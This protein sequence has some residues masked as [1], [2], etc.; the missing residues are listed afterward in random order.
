MKDN[1]RYE[2]VAKMLENLA[3]KGYTTQDVAQ[4]VR[5]M[6]EVLP[7]A[8]EQQD[9]A[10]Q[11]SLKMT[12]I[13]LMHEVGVP[14]HIKGYRYLC[15]AIIMAVENPQVLEGMT[16]VLYPEVAKTFGT[17]PSRTERAIRHAIEATWDRADMDV[18]KK[19]FGNTIS[20]MRGKATNSEFIATMAEYIRNYKM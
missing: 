5:T 17:T 10:V 4:L 12:V 1:E 13:G 16:K 18:L 8:P 11:E 19:Y 3:E 2:S 6:G 9:D 20:P 7:D 15:E 14:A